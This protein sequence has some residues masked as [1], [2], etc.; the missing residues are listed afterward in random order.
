MG[1]EDMAR[2]SPNYPGNHVVES[3]SLNKSGMP[4][5][6][7]CQYGHPSKEDKN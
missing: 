6:R 1:Y 2:D 7:M 4:W 5:G 3:S